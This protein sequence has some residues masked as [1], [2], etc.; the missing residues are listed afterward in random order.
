[1]NASR[2]AHDPRMLRPT[3]FHPRLAAL[4]EACSWYNWKGYAAPERL[5]QVDLEYF[6]IR[7]TASVFDLCPMTK[8]RIEG[9]EATAY[10]DR[11]FT[12][13]IAALAVGRVAYGVFC[14]DAGQVLDDG[15]LFRLAA[16]RY[17]LCVQ[18]RCLDWL[19]W[20]AL[21]FEVSVEDETD[22][23]AGLSLQGPTSCAVLRAMGL[24]EIELLKPF[25][26]RSYPFAGGELTVSRTGFTGDLG[27]ELWVE[28]GAALALWDAL[29]AAG[30]PRLIRAI[31]SAALNLARIEAGFIQAGADFVPAEQAIRH[32]RSRSPFELGL[33]WLVD[34]RKP[35]FTGR[36]ALLAE[37]E[38][39]SRYHFVKLEVDGNKPASNAFI[40]AADQ[41]KEVGTVTSAAWC[42]TA[43]TNVAFASLAMPHGAASETLWAEVYVMSE[44]AWRRNMARARVRETPV[45]DPPRRRQTPAPLF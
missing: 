1:M 5:E 36:R 29:F 28:P 27:Y 43:K 33:G 41:R 26:I 21:G 31:G 11:L 15:T 44:L 17:R 12:R 35:H 4:N 40:F 23:V 6:A 42:P 3:A 10:L 14:D 30:E 22:A 38:R 45:F 8:Y 20:S 37:Q 16:D 18:E 24:A 9:P 19:R 39:G 2:P 25:A 32:G 13:D 7:N 34:F